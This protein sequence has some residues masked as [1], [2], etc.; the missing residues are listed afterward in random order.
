MF[1]VMKQYWNLCLRV[2][3]RTSW[4]KLKDSIFFAYLQ[5]YAAMNA[6]TVHLDE[7]KT[8]TKVLNASNQFSQQKTVS[9]SKMQIPKLNLTGACLSKKHVPRS[10]SFTLS[11]S[12]TKDIASLR[13]S[14][15]IPNRRQQKLSLSYLSF[16]IW[17]SQMLKKVLEYLPTKMYPNKCHSFVGQYS[18]YS[19]TMVRIWAGHD[20]RVSSYLSTQTTSERPILAA[21]CS[22][23]IPSRFMSLTLASGWLWSVEW[24]NKN[25]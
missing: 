20:R 15:G 14:S 3:I 22:G 11:T 7:Q 18:R 6:L 19:S 8:G 25:I 24:W 5:P 21:T 2:K 9:K 10:H 17:P 4:A 13:P 1:D 16:K 23:V 12:I